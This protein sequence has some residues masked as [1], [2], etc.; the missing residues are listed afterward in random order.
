MALTAAGGY[1]YPVFVMI[2]EKLYKR[3]M[4]IVPTLHPEHL[5]RLQHVCCG[6]MLDA[7]REDRQLAGIFRLKDGVLHVARPPTVAEVEALRLEPLKD[8]QTSDQRFDAFIASLHDLSGVPAPVAVK[9]KPSAK[10]KAAVP[11]QKM[12][13]PP[14]FIFRP[15]VPA[16][17]E[18]KREED[19]EQKDDSMKQPEAPSNPKQRVHKPRGKGGKKASLPPPKP[20]KKPLLDPAD[21]VEA[22]EAEAAANEA[23]VKGVRKSKRAKSSAGEGVGK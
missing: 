15:A 16:F 21:N 17:A 11:T 7:G 18:G 14:P 8:K 6:S 10:T 4:D 23:E 5:E 1:R 22:L 13:K 20:K 9:G 3:V 19:R 12:P 2:M